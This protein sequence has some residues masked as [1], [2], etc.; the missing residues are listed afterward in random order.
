VLAGTVVSRI[1]NPS[2]LADIFKDSQAP[3][4]SRA[5]ATLRGVS[6]LRDSMSW[7]ID[8]RTYVRG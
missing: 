7:L 2:R 4:G 3:R 1:A 6:S 8:P 5:Y